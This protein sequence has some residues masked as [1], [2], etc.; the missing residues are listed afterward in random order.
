MRFYGEFGDCAGRTAYVF[1][2]A[3][4]PLFCLACQDRSAQRLKGAFTC[5]LRDADVVNVRDTDGQ[6][7]VVVTTTV[8]GIRPK[9]AWSI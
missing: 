7:N 8:R 2:C 1:A 6:G 9:A 5:Q 4:G 3:P